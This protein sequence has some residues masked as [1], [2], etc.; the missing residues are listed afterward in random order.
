VESDDSNR[1]ADFYRFQCQS[2]MQQISASVGAG[3][4]ICRI[5]VQNKEATKKST[6][7]YPPFTHPTFLPF[8]ALSSLFPFSFPQIKLGALG[9]FVKRQHPQ[10]RRG[11]N[12][13]LWLS[14]DVALSVVHKAEVNCHLTQ[15][16][17][18][19]RQMYVKTIILKLTSLRNTCGAILL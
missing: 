6:L 2:L 3:A 13:S 11:S 1:T 19:T 15:R 14:V 16:C 17:K 5:V 7:P 4:K 10:E 9:I 18:L 12:A 8:L